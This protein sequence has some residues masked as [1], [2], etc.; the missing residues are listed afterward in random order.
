MIFD[1]NSNP[2]QTLTLSKK[3]ERRGKNLPGFFPAVATAVAR[4]GR[5]DMLASRRSTTPCAS[6][7]RPKRAPPRC[8]S[9]AP[10]AAPA[11]RV[12]Q[13]GVP[14]RRRHLFLW[15][16][17]ATA[18]AQVTALREE[19]RGENEKW[20]LGLEAN[21]NAGFDLTKMVPSRWMQMNGSGFS[22]PNP[23]QAGR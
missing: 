18:V 19:R 3:E 5:A 8:H 13:R 14:R 16:P 17:P 4:E 23:A 9:M 6:A 1:F 15:S 10:C 12:H 11:A 20:G 7:R 2:V 22:G 21:G